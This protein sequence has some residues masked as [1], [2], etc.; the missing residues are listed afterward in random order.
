MSLTE[1]I[2]I[3]VIVPSYNHE[4][5]I[6]EAILSVFAQNY[7][8][9]EIILSDD[10]S[11][12]NSYKVMQELANNYS[13][14]HK[15]ILNENKKNLGLTAHVDLLV[16]LSH[17][18]LI[19]GAAGDDISLP[20]RV[21]KIYNAYV[22]SE[23]KARAIYS[24]FYYLTEQ[25][26]REGDFTINEDNISI[27]NLLKGKFY[28]H[29]A[30]S[31]YH[32]DVFEKFEP[33]ANSVAED[34]ILGFRAMLLGG[35]KYIPDML[36]YYRQHSNSVIGNYQTI[37]KTHEEVQKTFTLKLTGYIHEDALLLKDYFYFCKAQNKEIDTFFVKLLLR[38]SKWK[39]QLLNMNRK[40]NAI[41]I[42]LI[43]IWLIIVGLPLKNVVSIAKTLLRSKIKK[44]TVSYKILNLMRL[45]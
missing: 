42:V 36:I 29:G 22:N 43:S 23:Y 17:G 12:D 19:V 40:K 24:N 38:R 45:R 21:S 10:C 4:K 26:K 13:G 33:L 5:Y 1:K 7:S 37:S 32:R 2:L 8:P 28:T 25:G 31:C 3:S 39:V 41:K 27:V 6:K 30:V 16:S 14:P 35:I 44:G 34:N 15:I 11:K 9:L 20:D 18:Q